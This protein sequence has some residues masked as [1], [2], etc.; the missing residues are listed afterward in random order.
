MQLKEAACHDPRRERP[1]PLMI[2]AGRGLPPRQRQFACMSC[3]RTPIR[4]TH[5][6]GRGIARRPQPLRSGRRPSRSAWLTTVAGRDLD[7]RALNDA[8]RGSTRIRTKSDRSEPPW[9]HLGLGHTTPHL[10]RRL[11]SPNPAPSSCLVRPQRR[12]MAHGLAQQAARHPDIEPAVPRWSRASQHDEEEGDAA[13]APGKGC[14][15][16]A[17]QAGRG[18]APL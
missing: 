17:R 13:E 6:R 11:A 2:Q 14:A 9:P 15:P 1:C 10:A 8:G 3:M 18:A 7:L 4:I 16:G 12:P 5:L